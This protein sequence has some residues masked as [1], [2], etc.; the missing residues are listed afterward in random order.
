MPIADNVSKT[1]G[2]EQ[3]GKML[4]KIGVAAILL[5]G[6]FFLKDVPDEGKVGIGNSLFAL[7]DATLR[8][9]QPGCL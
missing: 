1:S 7:S 9:R 3:S 8:I 6:A 2:E 4:G 5:A